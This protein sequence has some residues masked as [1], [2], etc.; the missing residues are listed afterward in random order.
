MVKLFCSWKLGAGTQWLNMIFI[1][2]W[3]FCFVFV[4]CDSMSSPLFLWNMGG[5]NTQVYIRIPIHIIY[6]F[7]YMNIGSNIIDVEI[8]Y[9]RLCFLDC[10][11]NYMFIC[12][13]KYSLSGFGYFN[14][15]YN[16]GNFSYW[17]NGLIPM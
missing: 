9:N 6:I 15:V 3:Y 7:G 10:I 5:G 1:T 12:V 13:R 16:I 4:S 8:H 2:V 17:D 14:I 11:S